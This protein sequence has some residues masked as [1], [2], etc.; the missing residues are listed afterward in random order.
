MAD[1]DDLLVEIGTEEL[2]PTDLVRLAS[3]FSEE[4][5]KTLTSADL[6]HGELTWYATPRRL[7]LY[8]TELVTHQSAHVQERRGPSV[9]NAFDGQG[10][11]TK[12]AIGFARS[13]GVQ[14][15]ELE[16]VETR[17]GAYLIHRAVEEIKPSAMLIPGMVTEALS[18]LLVS[19][20]MRWGDTAFEFVR[21]VRWVVL[22][23]GETCI[24]T[25]VFGIK[26]GR[27]TYG[28]RFHAPAP[29]PLSHPR[30]YREQLRRTGYVIADHY[31]RRE[32]ITKEIKAS[33]AP[34][35]P[36]LDESLLDEVAAMVEWPQ[37][38]VGQF[39][40]EFLA[41]PSQVLI[42]S[43]KG[44]QR[45]FPVFSPTSNQALTNTFVTVSNIKSLR[46]DLVR[47][48]N[49]RV[50]RPRLKDAQFFFENDLAISLEARL[51]LLGERMF[52]EEIGSLA[53]KSQR[54]ATLSRY[55]ASAL[56]EPIEKA[57]LAARAGLLCKGDLTSNMVGEFPELQG[58]IGGQYAQRGG[59]PNEICQAIAQSYMPRFSGDH[60]PE[61]KIA[62]AVAC[63]DKLDTLVGIFGLGQLP[64]G[65]KDP[66]ALRRA[67]LGVLRM[68]I[69]GQRQLDLSPL[70]TAAVTGYNG[71][72]EPTA[73]HDELM[74]F[75]VE[76]LRAYFQ[77]RGVSSEA[78][79]AVEAKKLTTPYDFARRIEAV[80]DFCQRSE[81][82][83]LVAANKR[84]KNILR[85]SDTEIA[86]SIKASLLEEGAEQRLAE[87]IAVLEPQ[88]SQQI[89]CGNYIEALTELSSLKSAVDDFF[90]TVMVM[91]DDK[92]RRGN[93]LALLKHLGALFAQTADI[94]LLSI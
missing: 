90:D 42:A 40:P 85:Q 61:T 91:V 87:K 13:C 78:F 22:L 57:N 65:D 3:T 31:E 77:E 86:Q 28:H 79:A 84:I 37:V 92:T 67:A 38:I 20:R 58:Y 71:R 46:P 27:E 59:E 18:K 29:I 26:S 10:R 35:V 94:S 45:Y 48:G 63:A 1:T 88:V 23:L 4:F 60:L 41:L 54:V 66:Y 19:R 2:P 83:S 32:L 80:S 50:I 21:P 36:D 74:R 49:E 33:G 76:R 44:H 47:E 62:T 11:P 69:E 14:V 12:A 82:S 30:E 17:K 75:M 56:E 24:E 39:D 9:A 16:R 55:I 89:N 34:G 53:D 15:E 25:E 52:H 43:M 5:V 93:R 68:M 73:I 7:A 51:E 81:A 72:F 70:I 6:A 64:T 8:V